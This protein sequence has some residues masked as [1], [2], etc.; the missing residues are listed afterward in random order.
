MAEPTPSVNPNK[1]TVADPKANPGSTQPAEAPKTEAEQATGST[2][3]DNQGTPSQAPKPD[4]APVK[5]LENTKRVDS[6]GQAAEAAVPTKSEADAE[7]TE[8]EVLAGKHKYQNPKNNNEWET[9]PKGGSVW[10]PAGKA[11]RLV[12]RLQLNR[13]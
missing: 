3:L 4:D 12:D 5:D 10:L 6:Q 9:V 7:L 2:T 1:P 13:K 8:Y 11:T